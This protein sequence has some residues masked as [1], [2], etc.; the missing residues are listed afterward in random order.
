MTFIRPTLSALIERS[1]SDLD[2]RLP[3]ADSRLRRSALDVLGR[4]HAG[5]VHGL[6]GYLDQIARAILPETA[7]GADL[8]L[9]A[10]TWGITRKGAAPSTGIV[11]L[12][13][14][15]G[16]IV[17]TG[18]MLQRVDGARYRTTETVAIAA[19]AAA[20]PIEAV[21]GG[22]GSVLAAGGR[23]TFTSPVS[24]V[25]AVAIAVAGL[26]GGADEEDDTALRARL[27]MRIRT[28]PR[29]GARSDWVAWTLEVPGVTRAWAYPGWMGPGTVGVTFVHDGREDIV[30]TE[31]DLDAVTAH[32]EPLRP[33]CATPVVFAPKRLAVNFLIRA[34][35]DTP[36][37]RQAIVA[38]LDDLFA[39]EAEPGA[40][41]YL[42][43]INEA[44]SLAAGE[45]D[46]RI[47]SP[48]GNINPQRGALPVRGMV[49]WQ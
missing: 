41:L 18:A 29:G 12:A 15:D 33:I 35:P 34:T 32:L 3:G 7:E 2:L 23:L 22:A 4:T 16:A 42:S 9:R 46:H 40:L 47:L 36:V 44:I 8:D 6:Y 28:P 24:G 26:A 31:A 19:G 39:R 5:A 13:G 45:F 37:V 10:A 17:R 27:L 20:V 11:T 25:Q 14:V 1:L 38:E 30:P 49:A 48:G 43:R 21:E